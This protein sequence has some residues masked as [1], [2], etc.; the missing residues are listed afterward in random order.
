MAES[1]STD[2]P[3]PV[4]DELA[5]RVVAIVAAS[6]DLPADQIR[7]DATLQELGLDSLDGLDLFFDLE[8]AFDVKIP[9]DVARQ[10]VTVRDIVARL[11]DHLDAQPPEE[12][13]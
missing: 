4:S 11:A 8:E 7:L 13:V 12:A 3:P 2:A 1:S 9:D 6:R 5:A 10:I